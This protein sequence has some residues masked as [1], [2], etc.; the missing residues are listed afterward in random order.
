MYNGGR[1]LPNQ[2]VSGET[3]RETKAWFLIRVKNRLTATLVSLIMQH[4]APASSVIS[5][6]SGKL[7]GT[8]GTFRGQNNKP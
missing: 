7:T 3:C 2:W 1:L 4:V 6:M 8:W 5:Y